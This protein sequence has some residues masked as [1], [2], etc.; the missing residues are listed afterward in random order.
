MI[1]PNA[2]SI[3]VL[4]CDDHPV[5]RRGLAAIVAHESDMEVVG[6]AADGN[7]AVAQ[8]ELL[9]PDVTLIDLRMPECDGVGA[10]SAIRADH[11][12]ARLIVLTTYDGDEDIFRAIRAGAKSYLLKD[13]TRE[14]L[15]ASIRA[16]HRGQTHLPL[17]VAA[18]LAQS[19]AAP[20]LSERET[21]V[22]RLIAAGKSNRQIA[23]SL[24]LSESTVKTHINTL[25]HKLGVEDRT[26]AVTTALK[27][28]LVRLD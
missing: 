26:Q 24:F 17:D 13:A 15:L 18:K 27:R 20:T 25:L 2:A 21:D 14:E 7:E 1:A 6:E 8:W 11:P 28:G 12:L 19:V 4:L 3:R 23:K 22:L 10:I 16:V 9:R 5:V